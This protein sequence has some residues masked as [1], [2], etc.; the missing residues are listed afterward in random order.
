ML[1]A[2]VAEFPGQLLRLY[3]LTL[4]FSWALIEEPPRLFSTGDVQRVE[5]VEFRME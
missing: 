2:A 5:P 1:L 3:L 4:D